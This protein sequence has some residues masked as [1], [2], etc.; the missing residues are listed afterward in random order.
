ME[1]LR[2]QYIPYRLT[3]SSGARVLPSAGRTLV[4]AA[5]ACSMR[6]GGRAWSVMMRRPPWL[7]CG[8]WV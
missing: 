8:L 3:G 7:G 2:A 6:R 5:A 1:T 4:V